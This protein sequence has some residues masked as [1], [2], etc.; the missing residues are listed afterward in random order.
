MIDLKTLK[1]ALE[2]LE[3]ERDIPREKIIQA[4][5]D[6]IT[7]AYKKDYGKKGQIIRAH[8]DLDSGK[9]DFVQVKIAV[10]ESLV[11]MDKE[12]EVAEDDERPLFNPEHHITLEDA[13]RIKKDV[14]LNEEVI[15]PLDTKEDYGR[16][17][18]QTAKQVIIQRIREAEKISVL[19]EYREREGEIISGKVQKI[20]RGNVYI[21]LGR[22]VGFLPYDE[23]IP[24]EFYRQGER[25]RAYL[26]LVEETPRG[27][28]L[29]LSRAHPEFVKKLFEAEA[30]EIKNGVVE[31]RAIAREAGS[32][33]KIAVLSHDSSIDPVGSCVGGRG[34]RVA[35]V[36]SELGGEKIDIIEWSD[37]IEEFITNALSPAKISSLEIDKENREVKVSVSADQFSL[38]VGKGGQNVRLAAKLTGFRIDIIPPADLPP[39]D[40]E[41]LAKDKNLGISEIIE[42]RDE[43]KADEQEGADENLEQVDDKEEELEDEAKKEDN[44]IAN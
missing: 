36:I 40:K 38:A 20:D 28:N 44:E 41:L 14:Q 27:I 32:R 3:E 5:E 19:E 11:R 10:D 13:R 1:S 24:G 4:I 30:P 39:S 7:A 17:A 16:I 6:A 37:S 31:I 21:D 29:K 9:T 33:T 2:Q 43:V 12:E 26:Y 8:F 23:Q 35:T 34:A 25:I 22:T 15:F 18:A 42:E